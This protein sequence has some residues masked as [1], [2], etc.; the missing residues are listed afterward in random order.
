MQTLWIKPDLE[1]SVVFVHLPA[2]FVHVLRFVSPPFEAPL[3][4][5]LSLSLSSLDIPASL[6]LIIDV[7]GIP[8]AHCS[9]ELGFDRGFCRPPQ[10]AVERALN[11]MGFDGGEALDGV[12]VD[13]V[14]VGSCTNARIEDVRAVAA[15]AAGR[16]VASNVK[17]AMVVPGSGL[18]KAQ[19]EFE[20][21]DKILIEA[22]FDW[23]E[24]G[25]SM[26]LAM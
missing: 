18:V 5:M 13:K 12:P 20:G 1:H 8:Y 4:N 19:A 2:L 14:F 11:Y 26:C 6:D 9:D 23:R 22:G 25:C 7:T 3:N 17:T 16:T 10:E 24:P 21:L 15:V